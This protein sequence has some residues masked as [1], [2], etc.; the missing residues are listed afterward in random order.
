MEKSADKGDFEDL[1]TF[2]FIICEHKKNYEYSTFVH[3]QLESGLQWNVLRLTTAASD[4]DIPKI[5]L[6]H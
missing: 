5:E 3:R 1:D 2:F 4:D 6:Q